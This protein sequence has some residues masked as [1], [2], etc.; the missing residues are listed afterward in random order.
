MALKVRVGPDWLYSGGGGGSSAWADITDKPDT[1]TRWP[2]WA[3]VT[4]KPTTFTPSAHRHPWADLDNVPTTFAP[5]AHRHPWADLDNVPPTFTPSAHTH[6]ASQVTAGTFATG[7][8]SFPT[9]LTVGEG[10]FASDVVLDSTTPLAQ[11]TSLNQISDVLL[12]SLTTGQMLQWNGTKWVNVAAPA[13]GGSSAWADITGKPDTATRWPAWSEVTSKPTTF[14]PTAH[15]HPWADVTSPP[16]TATRWPTYAEVTDKP[17]TFAPSAHTHGAA[18]VNAGTLNDARLSTNIPRLNASNVFAHGSP[19]VI[20]NAGYKRW[21]TF[22]RSTSAGIADR[23]YFA[24]S[25]TADAND[26]QWA[27][28]IIFEPTGQI[29]AA[30]G[31]AVAAT[32]IITSARVLQNVTANASIITV[33]EFSD[34]RLSTNIARRNA[35]NTFSFTNTMRG[36]VMAAFT[37]NSEV[38][39][40]AY[41]QNYLANWTQRGG[42]VTATVVTGTATV[43]NP[44]FLVDAAGAG[45]STCNI[46]PSAG[47]EVAFEF[48]GLTMPTLSS[49]TARAYVQTRAGQ[50]PTHMKV[51]A[52]NGTDWV[53]VLAWTD[54]TATTAG[55]FVT[56]AIG[57]YGTGTNIGWRITLRYATTAIAYLREIGIHHRNFVP[58]EYVMA[59]HYTP[60]AFTT[61]RA[62]T[63]WGAPSFPTPGGDTAAT[64]SAWLGTGRVSMGVV[65]GG[66]G[67]GQTTQ[68]LRTGMFVDPASSVWGISTTWS[69]GTTPAFNI[70]SVTS[71]L[72]SITHAGA[73]QFLG[74]IT[75][76][77]I[78]LVSTAES[79]SARNT[80]ATSRTALVLHNHDSTLQSLIAHHNASSAPSWGSGHVGRL[81]LFNNGTGMSYVANSASGTH[82]FHV[83]GYFDR[84]LRV[85]AAGVEVTGTATATDFVLS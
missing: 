28:Q 59:R 79:V 49:V 16:A 14:P 27:N 81:V 37:D 76:P 82:D 71:T 9:R 68:G 25:A 4:S 42:T 57:S 24:P 55:M 46:T 53:E 21:L 3:E 8:F 51:D 69:A 52:H 36:L 41:W 20:G 84:R 65:S 47:A 56:N 77:G 6:P 31:Y 30:G 23:C 67:D 7:N 70:R 5:S 60:A 63:Q 66:A 11:G 38:V 54:M 75:T 62:G 40:S 1:A 61:V 10:V 26:W 72:L 85:A 13:G 12:T 33:G 48:T 22:H 39:Q 17:T 73:A 18:D 78:T 45:S 32:E 34:A 19:I 29:S 2:G 35:G 43:T 83:G 58:Y 15:T 50:Q 80:T 64:I 74:A 44:H